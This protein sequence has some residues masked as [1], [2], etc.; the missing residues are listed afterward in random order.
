MNNNPSDLGVD[1]CIIQLGEEGTVKATWPQVCP[2]RH[3]PSSEWLDAA[4]NEGL[5]EVRAHQP[6]L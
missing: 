5:Q 6:T 3:I 2:H 4:A 1:P